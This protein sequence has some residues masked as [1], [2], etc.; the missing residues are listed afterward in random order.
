MKTKSFLRIAA[1]MALIIS[2]CAKKPAVKENIS[3]AV[4]VQVQPVVEAHASR[5]I[6]CAGLLSSKRISKL[7]FKTGGIISRLYVDEGSS[8][9]KGQLLATLDMTEIT[10]Q[11]QQ[12]KVAYEK[13]DRDLKRAKNLYADSV[14]TLEQLQN[15]TSAYDAALETKNIAEFN[16]H[17][18]RIVAPANGKIISKLAEENEL[19]GP[20]MPVLVFGEQGSNEWVVKTGISDKDMVT[21]RKGDE[22]KVTFDAYQGQEFLA[23]VTQLAEVADPL[24]GT[25]EIELSVKPGDASFINGMVAS[26]QIRSSNSQRVSLIPPDAIAE[27]NG[28]KGFVYVVNPENSTAKRIPVTIAFVQND[29]IAVL[30]PLSKEGQLITKGAAFIEDG[31]RISIIR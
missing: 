10:A 26:I 7:S 17:Y 27:A 15:A 12:A 1:A 18:S 20:G 11:V 23:Q 29:G 24:S 9:V 2:S 21:I 14:V 5:T 4:C 16:Q 22:A 25:F 6:H 8:V 3:E 28:N 30:E 13:A 19:T 31:T